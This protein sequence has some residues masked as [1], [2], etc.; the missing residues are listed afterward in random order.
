MQLITVVY[1]NLSTTTVFNVYTICY[2]EKNKTIRK[3]SGHSFILK[4]LIV[5]ERNMGL[6]FSLVAFENS[7]LL[8]AVAS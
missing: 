8:L 3:Y 6:L 5:M 7:D 2:N 1:T 4:Y